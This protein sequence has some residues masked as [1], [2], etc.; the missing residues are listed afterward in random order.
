MFNIEETGKPYINPETGNPEIWDERPEGYLTW[1]E[2][3][4]LHPEE[5]Q[6]PVPTSVTSRQA[7][8][9]MHRKGLLDE[10]SAKFNELP[11]PAQTE[12]HIEWAKAT[13]IERSNPLVK[14]IQLMFDWSEEDLDQMFIE[15]S[16]I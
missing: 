12:V 11:E 7:H 16:E 2:Y 3:D 1:E 15:A 5:Q 14:Q 6:E 4:A 8:I 9:Y 10:I 13:V